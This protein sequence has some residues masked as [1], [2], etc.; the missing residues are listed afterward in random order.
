MKVPCDGHRRS[1]F[2]MSVALRASLRPIVQNRLGGL[3]PRQL[4]LLP[5]IMT[6]FFDVSGGPYGLET[7][8]SQSGAGM[9]LLLLVIT[10]FIWSLPSVLMT[11]ELTSA[12]PSEGGFYVWVREAMGPFAAFLTAWWSWVYSWVDISI[13]PGM[14]ISYLVAL[15]VRIPMLAPYAPTAHTQWIWGVLFL[16]TIVAVNI[17]GTRTSS[18]AN[19]VL[20]VFL[21]LPFAV[22]V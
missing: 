7:A 8:V 5:L 21:L 14:F 1:L 19:V 15:M 6:I 17:I 18:R 3:K 11:A 9:A 10:P 12:I 2:D 4:L 13:Y 16:A 20:G 22:V